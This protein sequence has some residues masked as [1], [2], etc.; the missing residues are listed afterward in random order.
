[1]PFANVEVAVA[2]VIFST[3]AS[4]PLSC[5]EVPVTAFLNAPA[6]ERLMP[7]VERM[8]VEV[9]PFTCV[10]V[11]AEVVKILPPDTVR[12]FEEESPADERAPVSWVEVPATELMNDPPVR[13][14][15]FEE[16]SPPCPAR[17]VPLEKVL[18]AVLV[19]RMELPVRVNPFE[20]KSPAVFTPPLKVEVAVEEAILRIP[21]NVEEALSESMAKIGAVILVPVAMVNAYLVFARIVVVAFDW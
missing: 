13:M 14:M 10:L 5:V 20:E 7:P 1:M 15:P 16:R 11:P 8:P 3:V 18:V 21:E 2:E 17:T 19:W 6:V 9:R 4:T 12:P